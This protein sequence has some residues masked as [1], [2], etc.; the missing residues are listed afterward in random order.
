MR[1]MVRPIV[2]VSLGQ[3]LLYDEQVLGVLPLGGLGEVELFLKA[4]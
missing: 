3:P 2:G 1:R 4:Q